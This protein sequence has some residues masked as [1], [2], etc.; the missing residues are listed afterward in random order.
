MLVVLLWGG[1]LVFRMPG[2]IRSIL[3][4]QTITDAGISVEY[5]VGRDRNLLSRSILGSRITWT[6]STRAEFDRLK[7]FA[8]AVD[9]FGMWRRRGESSKVVGFELSRSPSDVLMLEE[10]V[11]GLISLV[12]QEA[13]QRQRV[14]APESR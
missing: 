4:R 8:H 6:R 7:S 10:E 5:Q 9:N 14:F 1:S 11:D 3:V 13:R 12:T 2:A